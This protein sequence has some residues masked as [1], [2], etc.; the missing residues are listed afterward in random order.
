MKSMNKPSALILMALVAL[1][2]SACGKTSRNGAT[3][4]S[5][6]NPGGST[7]TP[8]PIPCTANCYPTDPNT[9]TTPS[10]A[11]YSYE[12]TQT[13]MNAV[14]TGNI[15]TDNVLKVKFRVTSNQGNHVHK[16]SELNVTIAVGGTEMTPTYT[17]SNYVYGLVG[18]T[19][20]VLDFSSYITPG[21]PVNIVVKAPKNNFYCTY[22]GGYNMDGSYVN[23]QY[24]SYP[25][26]R[27]EV[28]STHNWSGVIIVQTSATQAI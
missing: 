4:S 18:E 27:K 11:P 21:Q 24:G 17:T 8:T 23:P 20:N 3:S 14:A 15:S 2:L 13:G 6:L 22:W 9:P 26:C 19:S 7:S 12:F 16:A 28:H 25:G 10:Q 1:T 5:A